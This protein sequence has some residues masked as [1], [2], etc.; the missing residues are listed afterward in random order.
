M[1]RIILTVK[2]LEIALDPSGVEIDHEVNFE[3][4]EGEVLGLVG[5]SASGKTT[6]ATSLLNFQRRGAAITGG[7]ITIDDRDLLT[8]GSA[9]CASC[10]AAS[11]A[12]CRK[13][14]ARPSTRPCASACSCARSSK[15]TASARRT[16]SA[17]R[18]SPR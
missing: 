17:R 7:S 11:S 3:L 16:P 4:V 6:A 14:P 2:D 15:C 12:T 13:T 8:L 5:E 10:A 18:A 9:S 1:S